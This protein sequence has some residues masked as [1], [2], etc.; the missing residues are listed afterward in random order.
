MEN[1]GIT[2]FHLAERLFPLCRSIT[3][4]GF[5]KSLEIIREILPEIVVHEV[6]SGTQ[7]FDWIVPKEWNI[8]ESVVRNCWNMYIPFP[9]SQNGFPM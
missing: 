6:P 2:M 7:V 4:N 8:R 3:G 9:T 5:R 1:A